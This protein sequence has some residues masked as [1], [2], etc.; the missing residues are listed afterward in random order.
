[1]HLQTHDLWNDLPSQIQAYMPSPLY[2]LSRS[3]QNQ[4]IERN[5]KG[6]WLCHQRFRTLNHTYRSFTYKMGSCLWHNKSLLVKVNVT[7]GASP[8]PET[9]WTCSHLCHVA[10]TVPYKFELNSPNKVTK[11][12]EAVPKKKIEA[13]SYSTVWKWWGKVCCYGDWG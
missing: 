9:C 5:K 8:H 11:A 13:A 10:G 6:N 3:K 1:M 12:Y 2:S 7:E 4:G